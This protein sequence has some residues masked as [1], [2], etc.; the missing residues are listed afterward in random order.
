MC[1]VKILIRLCECSDWSESSLDAHVRRHVS[2]RCGSYFYCSTLEQFKRCI[3]EQ[4]ATVCPE[5]KMMYGYW[6]HS[7]CVEQHEPE[8]SEDKTTTGAGSTPSFEQEITVVRPTIS[9]TTGAG[10]TPSFERDY[11]VVRP[12]ISNKTRSDRQISSTYMLGKFTDEMA[13][14]LPIVTSQYSVYCLSKFSRK[15]IDEISL[16]TQKKR[17]NYSEMSC[18]WTP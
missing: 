17:F 14:R 5:I 11:T 3:Q 13:A 10:S 4:N 6:F 18:K 1:Q 12:T 8:P 15:H 9:S 16:D 7:K 2:W